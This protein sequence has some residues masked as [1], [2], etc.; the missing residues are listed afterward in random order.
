V[1]KDTGEH[2]LEWS[3]PGPRFLRRNRWS[4]ALTKS[5]SL[6]QRV[7]TA[8]TREV[9]LRNLEYHHSLPPCTHKGREA[10]GQVR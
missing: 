4:E 10:D 6:R 3:A 1:F 2:E 5:P 8:T 9:Q 7:L